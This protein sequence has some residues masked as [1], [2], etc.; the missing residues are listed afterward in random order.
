MTVLEKKKMGLE[1]NLVRLCFGLEK[2][3]DIKKDLLKIKGTF[4]NLS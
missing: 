4:I 2:E 1:K 3:E